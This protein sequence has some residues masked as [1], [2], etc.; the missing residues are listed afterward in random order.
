MYFLHGLSFFI[1]L[2][3]GLSQEVNVSYKKKRG[4]CLI[5]L[6]A[7]VS[8]FHIVLNGFVCVFM[9]VCVFTCVCLLTV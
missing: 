9:C 1:V 6:F 4:E 2:F 7:N 5:N 8:S 3:I